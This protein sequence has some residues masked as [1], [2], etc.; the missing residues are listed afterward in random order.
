MEFVRL[1]HLLLLG[2]G[3]NILSQLV[4]GHQELVLRDGEGQLVVELLEV[5]YH[6]RDAVICGLNRIC[7]D[8]LL[9]HWKWHDGGLEVRIHHRTAQNGCWLVIMLPF[10]LGVPVS[11]LGSASLLTLE[12]GLSPL[13]EAL[14]GRGSKRV[15]LRSLILFQS[16]VA[17]SICFTQVVL[18]IVFLSSLLG[19]FGFEVLRGVVFASHARKL[20]FCFFLNPLPFKKAL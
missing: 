13:M 1:L 8:V 20:I 5:V 10:G 16:L 11:S 18:S 12:F 15:L 4:E 14:L 6:C 17:R 3:F 2:G 7:H 9:G 19:L